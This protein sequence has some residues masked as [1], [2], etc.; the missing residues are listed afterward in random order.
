MAQVSTSYLRRL[1]LMYVYVWN[2]SKTIESSAG[3]DCLGALDK[4]STGLDCLDHS[5]VMDCFETQIT[6]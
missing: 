5:V 1:D 3:L 6:T 2:G 4:D